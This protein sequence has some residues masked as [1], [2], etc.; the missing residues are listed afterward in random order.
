MRDVAKK[1]GV[2]LSTVSLVINNGEHV[3][4]DVRSRVE[5]AMGVLN[6]VPNEMARNLSKNR[7]NLV[8]V[9][10]PTLRHP[11]FATLFASLQ[12]SLEERGVLALPCS[13]SDMKRGEAEYV[14]MLHRRMMDGIIMGAHTAHSSDYWTGIGHPVVAFDRYLGMGIPM[15]GSDHEQGSRLVADR[16]IRSGVRHVVNIGGPRS[17]FHDLAELMASSGGDVDLSTSF[18]SLSSYL[19]FRE[20][21]SQAGVR[22]DYMESGGVD[23]LNG[24]TKAAHDLF[25]RYP[26]V[27]AIISADLPAALCMREA[28]SRGLRIPDEVQIVAYDGTY[29]TQLVD[30]GMT[31]ICQDFTSIASLLTR[32][33]MQLIE[34]PS[35]DDVVDTGVDRVPMA[36]REGATTRRP[37]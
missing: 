14:E 29:V 5:W 19:V 6:Y 32:R 34:G 27:D 30:G 8:G 15:V 3:S 17:Q 10:M 11:F 22:W 20:M 7:T 9:I 4:D 1:A 24:Y 26:D 13:T 23:D 21:F 28:Q 35:A 12:T 31:A 18:P 25:D 2:S 16:L 37:E 36:L 33:L